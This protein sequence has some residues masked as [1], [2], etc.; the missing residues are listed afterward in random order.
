MNL[1]MVSSFA[2][3]II[4]LPYFYKNFS[5]PCT[6]RTLVRIAPIKRSSSLDDYHRRPGAGQLS[7]PIPL[8][9]G[10]T[11]ASMIL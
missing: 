6:D 11:L 2:T 5:G 4:P 9:A 1:T 3:E 7:H 10:T 8:E